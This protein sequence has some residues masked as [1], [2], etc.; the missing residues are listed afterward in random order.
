MGDASPTVSQVLIMTPPESD[1]EGNIKDPLVLQK[2]NA[3]QPSTGGTFC[4]NDTNFNSDCPTTAGTRQRPRP[5]LQRAVR[6]NT[7]R[8]KTRPRLP[9]KKHSIDLSARRYVHPAIACANEEEEEK[10]SIVEIKSFELNDD[11]ERDARNSSQYASAAALVG[12]IS[13]HTSSLPAY[14]KVSMQKISSTRHMSHARQ[15]NE[16]EANQSPLFSD[17]TPQKP[18]LPPG[19]VMSHRAM[20]PLVFDCM[21]PMSQ[22]VQEVNIRTIEAG[23]H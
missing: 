16:A 18:L 13:G 9:E 6:V 7:N 21:S 5:I 15:A 22:K 2:I 3:E 1:C 23:P 12:E 11:S 14:Q 4:L 8:R 17:T 20:R 19:E 10:T